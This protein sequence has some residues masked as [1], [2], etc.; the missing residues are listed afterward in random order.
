MNIQSVQWTLTVAD[1]YDKVKFIA[2]LIF[3]D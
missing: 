1:R 3:I 2:V